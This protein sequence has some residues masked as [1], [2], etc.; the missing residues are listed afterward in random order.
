MLAGTI[1][2]LFEFVTH[3][4]LVE[5]I[6]RHVEL[7]GHIVL[8]GPVWLRFSPAWRA[9]WHRTFSSEV[10]CQGFQ[11]IPARAR[12][13]SMMVMMTWV[14]RRRLSS[15]RTKCPRR[16][17]SLTH[18]WSYISSAGTLRLGISRLQF[19]NA[20]GWLR[21]AGRTFRKTHI[22]LWKSRWRLRTAHIRLW[23]SWRWLREAHIRLW[24]SGRWLRKA[25]IEFLR[26]NAQIFWFCLR[27]RRADARPLSWT[28]FG[29]TDVSRPVV[30]FAVRTRIVPWHRGQPQWGE[31]RGE[32]RREIERS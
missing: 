17:I 12:L 25:S 6:I 27:R 5:T 11:F 14:G 30:R 2:R 9:G 24:K 20:S 1:F 29:W 21:K 23:K 15:T 28:R 18:T 26:R 31:R 13:I 7:V 3:I 22:W 16:R 4:M 8:A 19:T 10:Q 32:A